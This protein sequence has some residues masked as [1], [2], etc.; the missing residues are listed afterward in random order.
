MKWEGSVKNM[1]DHHQDQDIAQG[2][3]G[4]NTPIIQHFWAKK[5]KAVHYLDMQGFHMKPPFI[6]LF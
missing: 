1:L 6:E 4:C 2:M 3:I 5:P